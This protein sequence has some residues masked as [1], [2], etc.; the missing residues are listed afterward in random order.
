MPKVLTKILAVALLAGSFFLLA[1]GLKG[2]QGSLTER[3]FIAYWSAGRLLVQH[4]NPY[5]DAAVFKLEK[6]QGYRE[7][8]PSGVLNPPW[9]MLLVLPLGFLSCYAAGLVWIVGIVACIMLAV[10]LLQRINPGQGSQDHLFAYAFAP[11]LA[12]IM[13]AQMSGV[14]CLG[15]VLFLYWRNTHPFA[16]GLAAS[17]L[18]IKPHLFFLFFLIL[19]LV[20]IHKRRLQ[21]IGGAIAGVVF[22]VLVPLAFDH[23]LLSQYLIR[24]RLGQIQ[25]AFIPTVSFL[26]RLALNRNAFWIQFVPLGVAT[27]W[28]CWYWWR[29]RSNWDWNRQGL[30][31]LVVSIWVAPYSTFLDELV[32]LPAVVA[33]IFF[34]SR[35]GKPKKATLPIFLG[36]NGIAFALLFAQVPVMSGAY[37]WS[38]TAWLGWYLYATHE[39]SQEVQRA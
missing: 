36:L 24:T 20:G 7:S 5:S 2:E 34:T 15:I 11:V 6:E 1:V 10:K 17:V 8:V 35:D 23:S 3:D 12:C 18:T 27:V 30:L 28:A 29:N 31:L 16:A 9:A 13:S 33:A 19:L 21:E 38:T 37:V 4:E 14:A 22:A 26:L 32:L 39:R 25:E